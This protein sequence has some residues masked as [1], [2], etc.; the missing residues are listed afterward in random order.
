[1]CNTEEEIKLLL[2]LLCSTTAHSISHYGLDNCRLTLPSNSRGCIS[3]LLGRYQAGGWKRGG[4]EELP[5]NGLIILKMETIHLLKSTSFLSPRQCY[6][7]PLRLHSV[8]YLA[9]CMLHFWSLSEDCLRMYV[10]VT[11]MIP[12]LL[13]EYLERSRAA[14]TDG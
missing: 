7:V 2:L 11:S 4:E 12:H 13:S 10:W 6:F 3:S 9:T 14:L 8:C 5:F 1:M